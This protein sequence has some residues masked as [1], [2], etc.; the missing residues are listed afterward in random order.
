MKCRHQQLLTNRENQPLGTIL[1]SRN[2]FA[3]SVGLLPTASAMTYQLLY[4]T[5][6]QS[7]QPIATVT[8]I[9]VP[10]VHDKSILVSYAV[11]ED[12]AMSSCAPS[13]QCKTTHRRII[14]TADQ[15]GSNPSNAIAQ[16]ELSLIQIL[17]S[18]G[19]LPAKVCRPELTLY[20]LDRYGSGLSGTKI[21]IRC[22]QERGQSR[23]G[24]RSSYKSLCDS[25][26]GV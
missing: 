6:D 16:A 18:Q 15:F 5:E 19:M 4:R 11:A 10:A 8:T 9:L 26:T 22:R 3:A 25:W 17:L 14:L 23:F 21:H 12:S 13:Y 24:Q 20:R 1:A 2:V 7:G